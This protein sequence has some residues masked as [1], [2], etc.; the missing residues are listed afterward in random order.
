VKNRV[1]MK[2]I[3]TLLRIPR[4][5]HAYINKYGTYDFIEKCEDVI[6]NNDKGRLHKEALVERAVER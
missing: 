3:A 2:Q 6:K 1:Q 4:A 5:H